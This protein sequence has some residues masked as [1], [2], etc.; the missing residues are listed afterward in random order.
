M[1]GGTVAR[2]LGLLSAH[3]WRNKVKH[4][5]PQQHKFSQ[6]VCL[7]PVVP[8]DMSWYCVADTSAARNHHWT[9]L[10]LIGNGHYLGKT[11]CC[12]STGPTALGRAR[13]W[14]WERKDQLSASFPSGTHNKERNAS[15]NLSECIPHAKKHLHD[16]K[17]NHVFLPCW[18]GFS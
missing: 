5:Q 11:W 7:L 12:S 8:P 4:C 13:G 18:P 10:G 16:T 6:K 9:S 3:P 14:W 2:T 17:G 1:A 15:A